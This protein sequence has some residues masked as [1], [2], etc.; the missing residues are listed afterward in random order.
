MVLLT[1]LAV[2]AFAERVQAPFTWGPNLLVFG[3]RESVLP[4]T[5]RK[6]D[7]AKLST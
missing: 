1:V 5:I 7:A 2:V 6:A 4:E 3:L